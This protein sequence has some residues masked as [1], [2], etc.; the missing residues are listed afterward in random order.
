MFAR[1]KAVK[2]SCQRRYD[3]IPSESASGCPEVVPVRFQKI[4]QRPNKPCPMSQSFSL[5]YGSILPTSL[6]YIIL[7]TRG[8]SP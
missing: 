8:C 3:Q 5:S 1:R 6:I 7:L 4:H 2:Q